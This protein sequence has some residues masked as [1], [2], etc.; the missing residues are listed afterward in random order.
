MTSGLGEDIAFHTADTELIDESDPDSDE[1]ANVLV[2][3][4]LGNQKMQLRNVY[5]L[6]SATASLQSTEPELL[7]FTATSDPGVATLSVRKYNHSG[8]VFETSTWI[9][10][11]NLNNSMSC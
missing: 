1:E 4:W 3:N 6:I 2:H 5:A 7:K 9:D 11:T 8:P 10:L